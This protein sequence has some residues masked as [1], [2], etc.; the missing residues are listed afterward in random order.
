MEV[1]SSKKNR[2]GFILANGVLRIRSML[3]HPS[4]L[5]LRQ[6]VN[7]G[8]TL[9][10]KVF[11]SGPSFNANSVTS[12]DQANQ[13]VKEQKNAGYDHLKIHPG[14]ELD[15]MWAISKAAK[16]QGIPFGGHVP[17]AVGLQNSLE[18]GF[19]SVEHMDGFLE[20]MLPDGFEID[21][22]SSGP[23]NLK[24]VHLVD[25]TKL[26][27]LIQLTLQKGVWMAPTLTLFDRY[28]GYI[29][30]DQFRKAPEMKYLPGIL[31][32]QWVNTK[33]Q[34]E[35]TG[36]LSKENVAPYLKF[37]NALFFNSIKREFR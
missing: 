7:S 35:A 14:V 36:V 18:S 13:M 19:K 34:L 21:P 27:S 12:P 25:S 6:R 30:A 37:R 28:F 4:H 16:E 9:G 20:A 29:P 10:P 31:I 3:G 5:D 2:C 15:E 24:L 33:K 11:I 22:T 8:Q 1:R 32:Q 23:F 17:L 26:P